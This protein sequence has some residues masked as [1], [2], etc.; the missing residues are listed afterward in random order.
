MS[1]Q[2]QSPP[3]F[4]SFHIGRNIGN[5][6]L[7][8]GLLFNT[9]FSVFPGCHTCGPCMY[10]IKPSLHPRKLSLQF[11]QDV[12]KRV[13]ESMEREPEY[14]VAL[15]VHNSELIASY[16]VRCHTFGLSIFLLDLLEP[17]KAILGPST[18]LLP[19]LRDQAGTMVVIQPL[20]KE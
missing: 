15:D 13:R 5:I 4:S 7:H 20:C 12:L 19:C 6:R 3:V 17:D 14:H 18:Q 11:L 16:E 9:F 10:S 2:S 8:R 1:I